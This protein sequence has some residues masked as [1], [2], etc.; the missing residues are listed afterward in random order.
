MVHEVEVVNE[1]LNEVM[2]RTLR[3]GEFN[4]R[5]R[6]F[7]RCCSSSFR[8]WFRASSHVITLSISTLRRSIMK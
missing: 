8:A 3:G 2:L 1:V 5:R 7:F 6:I 4:P